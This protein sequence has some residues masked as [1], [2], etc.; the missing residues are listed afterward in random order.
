M[1]DDSLFCRICARVLMN[2]PLGAGTLMIIWVCI[3]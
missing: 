3:G 1:L 2:P